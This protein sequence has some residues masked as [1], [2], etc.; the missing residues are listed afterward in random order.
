MLQQQIKQSPR[1]VEY[2]QQ[3]AEQYAMQGKVAEAIATYQMALQ[4]QPKSTSIAM[5]LSALLDAQDPEA[6]ALA[7][8]MQYRVITRQDIHQPTAL[9]DAQTVASVIGS[10]KQM[11][12]P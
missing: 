5:A 3:L 11:R 8:R 4:L 6:E 1:C 7:K 2:Y 9:A 10:I 12:M